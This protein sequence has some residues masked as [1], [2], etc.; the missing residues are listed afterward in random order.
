MARKQ[1]MQEYVYWALNYPV[2]Q[3]EQP[4]EYAYYNPFSHDRM[5]MLQGFQ[6][7]SSPFSIDHLQASRLIPVT[8]RARVQLALD[9]HQ[10]TDGGKAIIWNRPDETGELIAWYEN[11]GLWGATTFTTREGKMGTILART[12]EPLVERAL[13]QGGMPRPNVLERVRQLPGMDAITPVLLPPMQGQDP[14][15][16]SL[17]HYAIQ[18]ASDREPNLV[19]PYFPPEWL[20]TLLYEDRS[21]VTYHTSPTLPT[22]TQVLKTLLSRM[23]SFEECSGPNEWMQVREAED[24]PYS[25]CASQMR[26]LKALLRMAY[27]D[28]QRALRDTREDEAWQKQASSASS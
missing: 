2:L 18:I 1:T 11:I 5:R 10:V 3:P 17:H 26:D 12:R 20:V 24:M 28:F 7:S 21:M 4:G 8:M 25:V 13:R 14:A 22:V 15:L 27:P 9:Y 16:A 6:Y 19:S 23:R